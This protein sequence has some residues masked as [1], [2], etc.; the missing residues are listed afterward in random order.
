MYSL[1]VVIVVAALCLIVGLLLGMFAG[2]KNSANN[3][4]YREVE[5]KLDQVMQDKHAY[6]GAVEEHFVTTAKLFNELTESYRDVHTHLATGAAN[7]CHGQTPIALDR[8][9]GRDDAEIPP[10]LAN[11][12]PP[13]DYA[14]KSSP[15]E[16]GM[17]N[18]EFGLERVQRVA[19][20]AVEHRPAEQ[21]REEASAPTGDSARGEPSKAK[22]TGIADKGG[23]STAKAE[24]AAGAEATETAKTT[25][26][27]EK[28][29]QA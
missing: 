9:Q 4:K 13:L 26:K 2:N 22:A 29:E 1:V 11:I 24:P 27:I 15:E 7:L 5:R 8:L 12:R 20:T 23:D 10:H 3:K 14:P 21:R 18:E 28:T 6:E 17:L 25:E 19:S 16:K